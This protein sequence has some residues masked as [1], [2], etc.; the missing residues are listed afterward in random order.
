MLFIK[1]KVSPSPIHG[2][3]AFAEEPVAKGTLVW[4]FVPKFDEKL[5]LEDI[6]GLPK[7]GQ[8]HLAIHA[9]KSKKS[10]LYVFA[11][12]SAKYF[13]HSEKPN[14]ETRVEDG[15]DEDLTYASRDIAPGEELTVNYSG[16]E[17]DYG[18]EENVLEE[19][20]KMYDLK[21]EV[22]PRLKTHE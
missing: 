11:T 16:F 13:N 21:D 12:D 20:F 15:E 17:N 2:L 22:D 7:L 10:G 9:Y 5:T 1:A 18:M 3:G 6:L 19:I 4:K 8:I 14:C